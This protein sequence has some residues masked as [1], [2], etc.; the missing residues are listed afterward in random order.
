[1]PHADHRQALDLARAGH[2][3]EAHRLIQSHDDP[4][5][6]AIHGYLHRLEGDG[7]NAAYWYRRAGQKPVT[8]TADAE[9]QALSLRLMNTSGG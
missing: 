8:G 5:A 2:W 3:D 7:S 1:M 9:W 4:L 6:C